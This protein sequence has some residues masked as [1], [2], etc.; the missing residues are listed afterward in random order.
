[1]RRGA[2][3]MAMV[4]LAALPSAPVA[5]QAGNRTQLAAAFH[6]A[7]GQDREAARQVDRAIVTYRPGLLRWR[8]AQAVLVSPG[9]SSENCHSCSGLIAIHY[10][11][12]DRGRFRVTGAWLSTIG[13]AT[14]GAPPHWTFSTLLSSRPMLATD[15]DFGAQGVTCR[16]ATYYELGPAGPRAVASFT[17]GMEVVGEGRASSRRL[18][19]AVRNVVRGRAFDVVYAG[20]RR[21]TEHYVRRGARYV[22]ARGG[23]SG[24]QC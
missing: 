21:F 1:M 17:T 20:S 6:A 13:G 5:A 9:R 12:L 23:Q 15:T 11:T 7:F 14:W 4:A 2:T 8:G 19:G 16:Y 10:L 22:L 18:R 3:F 24:A